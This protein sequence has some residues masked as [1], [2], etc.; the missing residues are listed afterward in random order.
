MRVLF[1]ILWLSIM[2]RILYTVVSKHVHCTMIREIM[3][4]SLVAFLIP[5]FP[6]GRVCSDV[7]LLRPGLLSSMQ[8]GKLLF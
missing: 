1:G 7:P 4:S 2:C 5:E 8:F 6:K 3:S